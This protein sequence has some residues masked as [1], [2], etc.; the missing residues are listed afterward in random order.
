MS[1]TGY[2]IAKAYEKGELCGW[3]EARQPGIAKEQFNLLEAKGAFVPFQIRGSTPVKAGRKAF[4]HHITRRVLGKDT[5]NYPQE[6]GDCVSFGAKNATEYLTCAQIL[7]KAMALYGDDLGAAAEFIAGAR[8]KFR[9][10]FAPYYYGTGRVYVGRGQLGNGDGSL[11]SWMAEAVRKCGTL[12]ADE[13]GVPA[14]SG[15]IAKAWGD[16]NPGPDLDKFRDFAAA[17]TVQ[18][19]AQIRSWDDFVA[20]IANGYPVPTASNVGYSM[21][22]SSDGFHRQ[23]TNWAH[24]MCFIGVDETYQDDHYALLLNNWG[25]VHGRLKDFETGEDL[26]K[27]VLRVRRKDVEKHIRAGET[28]AYSQFNGFP[29]Q[30]LDK[31]LFLLV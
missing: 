26:P 6:I 29:E 9:P 15:R 30:K 18:S 17:Y 25:D 2:E 7:G 8:L 21:E 27:G 13:Q 1:T 3:L 16:P 23:T 14:Y 28:F 11:G 22:P 4:L 12:F 19:T 20:A 31:A 24:Q 10:V 5:P